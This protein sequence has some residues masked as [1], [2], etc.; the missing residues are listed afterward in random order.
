MVGFGVGVISLG[1]APLGA[2][3]LV[4]TDFQEFV[5]L[6]RAMRVVLPAGEGGVVHLLVL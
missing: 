1:G 5:R 4:T 2:T 3:S 6:G